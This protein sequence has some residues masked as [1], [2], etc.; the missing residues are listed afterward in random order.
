[1]TGHEKAA[2][3]PPLRHRFVMALTKGEKGRFALKGGSAPGRE[4]DGMVS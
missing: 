1:M 2:S 4:G 3:S